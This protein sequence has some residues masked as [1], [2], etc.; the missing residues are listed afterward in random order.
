MDQRRTIPYHQPT[1]DVNL[2]FNMDEVFPALPPQTPCTSPLSP[3]APPEQHV[4]P[5]QDATTEAG[6]DEI[7]DVLLR[8][9][10]NRYGSPP[11][12]LF[13]INPLANTEQ[14][15][16]L[17]KNILNSLPHY[18]SAFHPDDQA[19]KNNR[20]TP[21]LVKEDASDDVSRRVN[22]MTRQDPPST[23]LSA[24]KNP[25]EGHT[26][27]PPHKRSK[28]EKHKNRAKIISNDS[29]EDAQRVTDQYPTIG[30]S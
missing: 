15:Y 21:S 20:E 25:D 4:A 3:Q 28:T 5:A 17:D 26:P 2:A 1:S 6:A 13:H 10:G 29:G 24:L 11:P 9:R 22:K 16:Q 19:M 23:L 8:L 18:S 14:E 30:L 27:L 7:R 12:P